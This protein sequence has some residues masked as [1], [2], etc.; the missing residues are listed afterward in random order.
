MTLKI[1]TDELEKIQVSGLGSGGRTQSSN[2][3]SRPEGER[4][5]DPG[6]RNR[7]SH[8]GGMVAPGLE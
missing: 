6:L 1:Q 3:I 5:R 7:M 4:M 8:S 2:P